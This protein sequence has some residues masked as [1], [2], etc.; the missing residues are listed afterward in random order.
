MEITEREGSDKC[1]LVNRSTKKV[2]IRYIE[3]NR[4]VDM[5]TTTVVEQQTRKELRKMKTLSYRRKMWNSR[6]LMVFL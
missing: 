5:E 6:Q 1:D 4:D 3:E 2:R